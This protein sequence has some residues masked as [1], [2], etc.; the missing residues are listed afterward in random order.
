MYLA[1]YNIID[2]RNFAWWRAMES[3]LT[4]IRPANQDMEKFVPDFGEYCASRRQKTAMFAD[5]DE[6]LVAM[7]EKKK[8]GNRLI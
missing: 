3:V 1:G 4:Y 6:I 7:L 8:H 2:I 5:N